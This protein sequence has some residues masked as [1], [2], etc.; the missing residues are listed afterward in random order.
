MPSTIPAVFA[1]WRPGDR[2]IIR[3]YA[4]WPVT[5]YNL[6]QLTSAMNR[7]ADTSTEAVEQIQAWLDEA[8]GLQQ[9]WSD[10]VSDG[11]AHLG[12]VSRYTGPAPGVALSRDDLL[13]RA[14]VLEW[15]TELQQVS[16]ESGTRADST[17]G[18]VLYARVAELKGKI[19]QAIGIQAASGAGGGTRLVRS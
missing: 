5:G 8:E 7:V 15:A 13:K 2:E 16:Y 10:K 4:H 18:G 3:G 11:T 9:D 1:P 17:A 19:L 6:T 14:D 12:N